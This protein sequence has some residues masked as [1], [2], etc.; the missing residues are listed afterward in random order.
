MVNLPIWL[1]SNLQWIFIAL[2]V[3]YAL[4]GFKRGFFNQLF[5]LISSLGALILAY[6]LYTP[7]ASMLGFLNLQIQTGIEVLDAL[8]AS[9][10][11]KVLAFLLIFIGVK[12]VVMLIKPIFNG[13]AKLPVIKQANQLFGVGLGLVNGLIWVLFI[14]IVLSIPLL[15]GGKDAVN[16]TF[17]GPILEKIPVLRESSENQMTNISYLY[18][19]TSGDELT[20]EQWNSLSTWLD[21]I[22]PDPYTANDVYESLK[23]QH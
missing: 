18:M 1:T 10:V 12:I 11:Y 9:S 2:I 4:S 16:S 3:L 17:M 20:D 13:I 7:V 15:N 22:L 8:L 19:A 21:G 6:A 5:D 23:I 14:S